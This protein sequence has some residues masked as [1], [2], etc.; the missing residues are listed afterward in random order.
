MTRPKLPLCGDCDNGWITDEDGA[1]VERCPCRYDTTVSPQAAKQEGQAATVE[2]NPQAMRAALAIILDTAKTMPVLSAND[3]R[4][5]MTIA[6][7]PG[8]VVGPAFA[9]ACKD[10]VLR[11]TGYVPS[12]DPGTKAHPVREYTSLVYRRAAS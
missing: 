9:Q 7:V 2:A 12:T 3:V 8:T 10:K 11:P 6:Q 1:L 4:H 5:R